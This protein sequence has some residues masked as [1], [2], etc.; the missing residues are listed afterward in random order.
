M[1]C[2]WIQSLSP[3][4]TDRLVQP[5]DWQD[6][7]SRATQ[8]QEEA[9]HSTLEAKRDRTIFNTKSRFNGNTPLSENLSRPGNIE[10]KPAY[11]YIQYPTIGASW[12]FEFIK[13]SSVSPVI[14]LR[15]DSVLS[16][17]LS[18]VLLLLLPQ[19]YDH[20]ISSH[21]PSNVRNP[22]V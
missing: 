15:A 8:E 13:Y 18:A 10:W 1:S 3:L 16:V 7:L 21:L 12:R 17:A 11:N 14:G 20:V 4:Y 2:C 9:S 19:Y 5:A 22:V 6:T